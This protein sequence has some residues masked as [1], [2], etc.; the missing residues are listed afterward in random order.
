MFW[1]TVL[2]QYE[3][4]PNESG[5]VLLNIGRKDGFVPFLIHSATIIISKVERSVPETVMTPSTPYFTDE[6]VCLGSLA[7]PFF[8]IFV[9]SHHTDKGSSLSHRSIN[10]VPKL[11]W[12]TFVLTRVFIVIFTF[13]VMHLAGAFIQVVYI[14]FKVYIL[15]VRALAHFADVCSVTHMLPQQ[16][17]ERKDYTDHDYMLLALEA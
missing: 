13:T 1:V 10:T 5:G 8:S 3:A 9:L 2:R 6:A 12:L 15:L 14:S 16:L 17:N 11:F 4:L 7:V